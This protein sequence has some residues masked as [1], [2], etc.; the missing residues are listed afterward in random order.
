MANPVRCTHSP[1]LSLLFWR[2][3]CHTQTRSC[4]PESMRRNS[5]L[6]PFQDERCHCET[7]PKCCR[8]RCRFGTIII[9]V[10]HDCQN[11]L[12]NEH[13]LSLLNDDPRAQSIIPHRWMDWT[14]IVIW[15]GNTS[16]FLSPPPLF[17]P[18]SDPFCPSFLIAPFAAGFNMGREETLD[19]GVHR[20]A[21]PAGAARSADNAETPQ[22]MTLA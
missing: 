14:G 21:R 10:C 2:R 4:A 7:T 20:T 15:T 8:V 19:I 3:N 16:P 22:L 13:L 9:G 11:E 18:S 1:S 6:T 17:L 5:C 12:S